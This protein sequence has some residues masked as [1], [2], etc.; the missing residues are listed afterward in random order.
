[1]M[2]SGGKILIGFKKRW[3]LMLWLEV[4][5]YALGPAILIY[6]LFFN[7]I[8]SIATL[9]LIA[10]L[11]VIF[12][13][14]WKPDLKT[15][16]SYIDQ[17]L[18]VAE[19]STGLLLLPK[20]QLSDLAKLQQYRVG[21]ELVEK[22]KT[23]KP[24]HHLSRACI[25]MILCALVGFM[26]YRY[27]ILDHL[28][29]SQHKEVRPD[30]IIFKSIDSTTTT[31]QPKLESQLLTIQYPAYTGKPSVETSKM[32]IKAVEGSRL[33]W[34]ITFDTEVRSVSM[35]SMG[36]SY[37]MKLT[38]NGYVRTSVL[39][40]S[41]FYNFKFTDMQ[42]TSYTSELY[43]IEVV[44]DKK[45]DIKITDL[46]QFTSFSYE[47][48]KRIAF[49]TSVTDDFGIA[50]TYIIATV[51]KGSGE[52]VKFRE[53][54]LSFDSKFSRGQKNLSLSKNIDLDQ[55]NME[56][57]DE[58]YFYI[59]A[60]DLKHPRPNISRSETFFAVIKDTISD[61]FAVEGTMGVDLM[62]D[63]FR[64]QRQLI[65]DTEKLIKDKSKLSEKDFKF[66]SN[67]L[68]FD[69]KVLRLK[70]GEFMGDESE[71]GPATQENTAIP[72][73]ED[74]HDD[75]GHEK[76]ND[77][78]AAYTHDHDHE[79]E[80]NLVPHEEEEDDEKGN[81]PL[82]EYLHN[83]DDPE[84]STLFTQSLKS[85]LRQALNE[86]WDAELYLRLYTPEKSLPY[87][88]K[89]LKLIQ[90]IKNSARVY[91]HRIG[92]DPPP[93]KEDKRLTGKIDE[94]SN[95]RK[96]EELQ[97]PELYP[98]I[99]RTV[100]R[101]EQLISNK[102]V[103]TDE[104]RL[105]FKQAGNEL[106]TKA[107][108]DPGKYLKTLQQLKQITEERAI[109]RSILIEVQRGLFYVLPEL[110]PNPSKKK[111]L[112]GEINELLLKELQIHD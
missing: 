19:Y 95:F 91:V 109:S 75:E 45:P 9:I 29:W 38:D 62:P 72:E 54:K 87:Q 37:P 112:T 102:E 1:M 5:L 98:S 52:S 13:K 35:E 94:V 47:E 79:N 92:F 74:E 111:V 18:D 34:R 90:E 65:I 97:L 81:D 48:N 30:T 60:L 44:K 64:S 7:L 41:G 103:L 71:F 31:R 40:T 32:E 43:S 108:E 86:M 20:E 23:I 21:K 85:K 58:L 106:A 107:I 80:H 42:E 76:E 49:T 6:F 17:H 11:I 84:E 100:L 68:G 15:V 24:P 22:L 26:G 57:G 67:E 51:S 25:V 73:E 10:L 93:I 66:K 3:H 70:Y 14:P 27:D 59:E 63:Y 89:A 105:L 50:E 33:S 39:N 77:P 110:Q 16:S 55:M 99:Y 78:L 69:Q 28:Q 8:F 88:Y 104:D 61:R 82:H 53:E 36:N 2:A 101:L 96:K 56:P 46:K 83:H 4:L 12:V